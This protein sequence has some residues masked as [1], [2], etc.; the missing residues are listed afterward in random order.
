MCSDNHKRGQ[1][2]RQDKHTTWGNF[3]LLRKDGK[4]TGDDDGRPSW[5]F[6]RLPIVHLIPR[7]T[8]A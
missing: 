4:Q 8:R 5:W 1:S 2:K 7:P 3:D 6:T